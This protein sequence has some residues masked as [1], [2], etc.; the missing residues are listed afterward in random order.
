[1]AAQA[2]MAWQFPGRQWADVVPELRARFRS[3]AKASLIAAFQA[4][5][6]MLC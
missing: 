2:W 1:M 6:Q 3:G 4:H 5:C